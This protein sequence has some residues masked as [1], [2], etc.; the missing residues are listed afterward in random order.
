MA[1]PFVQRLAATLHPQNQIDPAQ[2]AQMDLLR[3]AGLLDASFLPRQNPVLSNEF[4]ASHPRLGAA[5]NAA[6]WD[7]AATPQAPLVSGAGSGISRTVAGILA[8]PEMQ[9]QYETQQAL[10]PLQTA[11]QLA[12]LRESIGLGNYY[13]SE[14]GYNSVLPY[15]RLQDMEQSAASHVRLDKH[16]QAWQLGTDGKW[17]RNPS[18]DGNPHLPQH[19]GSFIGNDNQAHEIFQNPDGTISN[20][21]V[22]PV[23]V[24]ASQRGAI[25]PDAAL[26]DKRARQRAASNLE[27]WKGQQYAKA[28]QYL[29]KTFP[30]QSDGT[31]KNMLTGQSLTPGQYNELMYGM[32]QDIENSYATARR[33]LGFKTET[34]HY[35][36]APQQPAGSSTSQPAP[37][38]HVFSRSAWLKA[39]PGGDVNAA[40]AQ[41]RKQGYTVTK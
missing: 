34:F 40:S 18:L 19:I 8:G 14:A 22:G 15:L 17:T 3:S 16:G 37:T 29:A 39:N 33:Q 27:T 31:Y 10:A 28:N 26:A 24:P 13:Q 7:A 25:T 32:Y 12:K 2:K 21:P 6:M 30:R 41:A 35:H 1:I 9:Q 5:L 23:R 11:Q 36:A 4:I 38:S 20:L